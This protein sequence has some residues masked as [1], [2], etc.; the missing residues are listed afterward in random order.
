MKIWQNNSK[1]CATTK[2]ALARPTA[3]TW[4]SVYW[5]FGNCECKS[6]SLEESANPLSASHLDTL[7]RSWINGII[8]PVWKFPFFSKLQEKVAHLKRATRRYWTAVF[9]PPWER[10][11]PP[12]DSRDLLTIQFCCWTVRQM[13]I[14]V[15]NNRDWLHVIRIGFLCNQYL[16]LTP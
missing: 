11:L 14:R 3:N 15:D 1:D 9:L 8:A 7:Y 12:V 16:I 4:L 5:M 2:V 13:Q 10:R 6:S